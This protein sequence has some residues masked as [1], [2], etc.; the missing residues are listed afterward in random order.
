MNG[1]LNRANVKAIS[2]DIME[3]LKAV[4]LKYGVKFSYKGGSFSPSNATYRIEAAIVGNDGVAETRERKDY[5]I[6]CYQYGL[7]PEWLDKSFNHISDKYTIVGLS[8]RKSKNPVLCRNERSGKT[9]IFP[10]AMV[11]LLMNAQIQTSVKV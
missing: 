10:D 11:A 6:Y 9:F 1:S 5:Q 4:S 3:A 7:K 2:D 8:T